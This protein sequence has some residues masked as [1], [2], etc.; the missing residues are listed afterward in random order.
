MGNTRISFEAAI[1]TIGRVTVVRSGALALWRNVPAHALGS[2]WETRSLP[3]RPRSPGVRG[4]LLSRT[5]SSVASF[6]AA[7]VRV[8]ASRHAENHPDGCFCHLAERLVDGGQGRGHPCC[9][10]EVV[11]ADDGQVARDLH[12]SFTCGPER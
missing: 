1:S 8:G 3:S 7:R 10:G 2:E 9:E 6:D 4:P 12:V 11:V 5:T